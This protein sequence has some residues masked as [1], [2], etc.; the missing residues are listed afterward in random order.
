LVEDG[1][2]FLGLVDAQ[3]AERLS[4]LPRKRLPEIF[5][6]AGSAKLRITPSL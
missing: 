1:E 4:F 2:A 3:A 5:S 6:A